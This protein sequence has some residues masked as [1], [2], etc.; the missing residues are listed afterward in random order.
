MLDVRCPFAGPSALV[1]V[2][3]LGCAGSVSDAD[4]A[5]LNCTGTRLEQ[6]GSRWT[7]PSRQIVHAQVGYHERVA[8]RTPAEVVALY[9]GVHRA[10]LYWN[11]DADNECPKREAVT[12]T[13]LTVTLSAQPRCSERQW[14]QGL[15]PGDAFYVPVQVD[16]ATADGRVN[17]RFDAFLAAT[18]NGAYVSEGFQSFGILEERFKLKIGLENAASSGSAKLRGLVRRSDVTGSFPTACFWK[19]EDEPKLSD[20]RLRPEPRRALALLANRRLT[21][22]KN[23]TDLPLILEISSHSAHACVLRAG[24][25]PMPRAMPATPAALNEPTYTLPISARLKT[26]RGET[27]ARIDSDIF[28]SGRGGACDTCPKIVFS[29]GAPLELLSLLTIPDRR[30]IVA[31]VQFALELELNAQGSPG[32]ASGRLNLSYLDQAGA[33][34][35]ETYSLRL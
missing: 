18:P 12:A 9:Q 28:I 25:I 19:C 31:H 1:V 10:P 15:P 24:A 23:G 13:E 7:C 35:E 22:T 26:A 14:C 16:V 6:L 8:G 34:R 5:A 11:A 2:A 21:A 29:G 3:A 4:M 32:N 27:I 20:V 30:G 33:E 17:D